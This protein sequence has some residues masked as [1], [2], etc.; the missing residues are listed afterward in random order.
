MEAKIPQD[1]RRSSLSDQKPD[2]A[3][4]LDEL[5]IRQPRHRREKGDAR[6]AGLL[7]HKHSFGVIVWRFSKGAA[8]QGF[9]VCVV[10]FKAADPTPVVSHP[11]DDDIDADIPGI[12]LAIDAPDVSDMQVFPE[13]VSIRYRHGNQVL[14]NDGHARPFSGRLLAPALLIP[15]PETD[16]PQRDRLECRGLSGIVR[17]NKNDRVAELD[18]R[19]GKAFEVADR[20]FGE[21]V[22]G[23]LACRL[24]RARGQMLPKL[25]RPRRHTYTAAVKMAVSALAQALR[26]W[27]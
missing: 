26:I 13:Q 21:H 10:K 23:S 25:R 14:P 27:I 22:T 12:R 15:A 20:E 19:A 6:G 4:L 18:F 11:F 17:P 5:P 9:V 3:R 16:F 24:R 2:L 8:V 1:L 7:R